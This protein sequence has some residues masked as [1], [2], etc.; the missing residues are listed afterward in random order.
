MM[1]NGRPYCDF[2]HQELQALTERQCLDDIRPHGWTNYRNAENHYCFDCA[3]NAWEPPCG[4]CNTH[5]C[6]RGRD[7]WACPPLDVFPYETYYAET[8][9]PNTFIDYPTL[10]DPDYDSEFD[11]EEPIEEEVLRHQRMVVAS[12]HPHQSKLLEVQKVGY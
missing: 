4:Q 6:E 10:N 2:C 3:D 9:K 5:P 7:C 1:K 8:L 12:K 11:D